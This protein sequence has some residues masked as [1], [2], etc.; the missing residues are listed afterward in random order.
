MNTDT[1]LD[2]YV[3]I[4][5]VASGATSGAAISAVLDYNEGFK[6]IDSSGASDTSLAAAD[7]NSAATSGKGTLY[8]RKSI[9]T[10][11]AVALDTNVLSAGSNKAIARVK[12]TADTA[13]DVSW[14]KIVFTVSKTTGI[15]LGATTT[16]ALYDGANAIAGS[17]A[18]TTGSLATVTDLFGAATSGFIVFEPTAEQQVAAGSSKTYELRTTVGGLAANSNTLDVSVANP[19]SSVSTGT[20][21][22]IGGPAG[23]S[24]PSLVWSDRS[25]IDSVHST[26]TSDWTNDYLVK[27]LPL[28]VGNLSVTI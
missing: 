23:A 11:S 19:T 2:V 8:V 12:V 5:T 9:P 25:V 20:A 28:T 10:V 4:P 22:A 13:G 3:G 1:N 26:S 27:T 21:S 18:T 16:V 6:A 7:L 14:N 15:T 17:F 24:T